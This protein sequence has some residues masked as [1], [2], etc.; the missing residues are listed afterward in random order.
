MSASTNGTPT[1]DVAGGSRSACPAWCVSP[2]GHHLGE[3]DWVHSGEPLTVA[4]GVDA[5]ACM[6]VDPYTG[7]VDGPYLI[8]G[9]SQY[10]PGE[11]E[12]LGASLIALARAATEGA[13]RPAGS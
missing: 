9:W 12:A 11:A 5:H 1:T 6:S 10:T 7:T 13:T 2:H 8:I 3:E 4:D